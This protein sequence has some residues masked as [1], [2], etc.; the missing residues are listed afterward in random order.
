M[1]RGDQQ[2]AQRA[3]QALA[4]EHGRDGDQRDE[5]PGDQLAGRGIGT[6]VVL[7]RILSSAL[8]L[9]NPR[10]SLLHQGL[11]LLQSCF[12]I[13][14]PG[15]LGFK[16][17]DS[18]RLGHAAVGNVHG[19]A[20]P[21]DGCLH[22]ALGDDGVHVVWL[23]AQFKLDA[24]LLEVGQVK[25]GWD[26]QHRRYPSLGELAVGCIRRLHVGADG[27]R[28]GKRGNQ[29]RGEGRAGLIDHHQPHARVG[30]SAGAPGQDD[31]EH[32][33]QAQEE[34]PV[35]PTRKTYPGIFPGNGENLFHAATPIVP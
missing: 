29:V 17:L 15:S 7:D 22:R 31:G 32:N 10:R 34:N 18:L 1:G 21:A 2:A 27:L 14:L 20:D 9:R 6:R 4:G 12:E 8:G 26:D 33:R 24:P 28:L 23:L 11:G 13:G 19:R 5:H 25:F 3:L 35:E 30:R 16:R